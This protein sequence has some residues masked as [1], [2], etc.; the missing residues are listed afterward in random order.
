VR[1]AL[2]GLRR[3]VDVD[4]RVHL[5]VATTSTPSTATRWLSSGYFKW[6]G[7]CLSGSPRPYSL[8]GSGLRRCSPLV[9]L[10]RVPPGPRQSVRFPRPHVSLQI[11]HIPASIKA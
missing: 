4:E 9:R 3:E 11:F 7:R 1:A 5:R 10:E 6:P 8:P 2:A